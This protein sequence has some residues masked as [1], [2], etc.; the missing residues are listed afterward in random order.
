MHNFSD[1][2]ITSYFRVKVS[3]S[4]V[5]CISL[6]NL[7]REKKRCTTSQITTLL[8]TL[9]SRYQRVLWAAFHSFSRLCQT[10][11]YHGKQ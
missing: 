3:K 4:T 6:L 11:G 1:H 2:Y 5:S 10:W 8:L 9:E 7:K